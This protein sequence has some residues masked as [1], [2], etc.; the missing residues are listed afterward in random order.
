MVP[1]ALAGTSLSA[2]TEQAPSAVL[3]PLSEGVARLSLP[4]NVALGGN[5]LLESV[6]CLPLFGSAWAK[7][8]A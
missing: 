8:S 2:G 1:R 5:L 3:L 7:P 4:H 6:F